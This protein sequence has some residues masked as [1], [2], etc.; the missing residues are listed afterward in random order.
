M[1]LREGNEPRHAMQVLFIQET[2]DKRAAGRCAVK[3][4]AAAK[5]TGMPLLLLF[6]EY[7]EAGNERG[8]DRANALL[9]IPWWQGMPRPLEGRPCQAHVWQTCQCLKKHGSGRWQP[10]GLGKASACPARQV[11]PFPEAIGWDRGVPSQCTKE[12]AR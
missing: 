3:F 11:P 2:G 7:M 1:P 5:S 10:L 4:P 12:G 8:G 6:W 9:E